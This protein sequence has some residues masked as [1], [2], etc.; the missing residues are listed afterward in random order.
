MACS[1][2]YGTVSSSYWDVTT[3][4]RSV[5]AGISGG[6][7]I[8]ATGLT[9]A[10][11]YQKASY[12][13]LDFSASGHW[14][15]IEGSTRPL[16][17]MEA[18]N[19][20]TNGHA[21]QL[22]AL[23][24]DAYYTVKG[25]IDLSETAN[26]SGIW[27]A[28]GFIPIGNDTNPFTGLLQAS[29]TAV[30]SGLAMSRQ[31]GSV[32]LVGVLGAHGVISG[33][34][35]V[36]AN[37]TGTDAVGALVGI[38][39][40]L[41]TDSASTG[42][43]KGAKAGGLVGWN[44]GII[45]KSSSIAA[46]TAGVNGRVG[47]LVGYQTATGSI[48]DAY[49]GGA[50]TSTAAGNY[51][52]GLV[53]WDV[54]GTISNAY[55]T[56]AV[57]AASGSIGGGLVGRIS[58]SGS[59]VGTL[60]LGYASG[61]VS[62]AGTLGGLVGQQDASTSLSNLY[63]DSGTTAQAAAIGSIV[64]GTRANLVAVGG[65]SGNDAYAQ[66]TYRALNF[67]SYWVI[68]SGDTRPMLSSELQS[69][70]TTPHQLQMLAVAPDSGA[71][72][73]LA[74]DING[75]AVTNPSDVW[76]A[77]TGFAPIGSLSGFST[78]SLDGQNHSISNLVIN[79]PT[80]DNVGLFGFVRSG[81]IQ[82][83]RLVG[84]TVNGGTDVGGLIGLNAS[85]MV[86]SVS[87]SMAVTGTDF[88][89]G[90]VGENMGSLQSSSDSGVTSGGG[91]V[92]GLAG[93]NLGLIDRSSATGTV[94][95]AG[96]FAGGAIGKNQ[97]LVTRTTASGAVTGNYMVGGLT[98]SNTLGGVIA[99][100]QAT[101]AVRGA[102]WTGGLAGNNDGTIARSWAGGA[103]KSIGQL[104]GGL[105][106]KNSGTVSDVY[107]TGKVNGGTTTGGLIG[108][109]AGTATVIRGYAAGVVTGTSQVG[110]VVGFNDTGATVTD[111]YWDLGTTGVAVAAGLDTGTLTGVTAIGA[112]TSYPAD[113]NSSYPALDF[114]AI[115]RSTNSSYGVRPTLDP[116]P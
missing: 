41:I 45:T 108:W 105:I 103:V 99:G 1:A 18:S 94:T 5:A 109:N 60:K 54:G 24:S 112:G 98:G 61:K 14:V 95:T 33:I 110:G 20:I 31:Y 71:S 38:N 63:W 104:T 46:V 91:H 62:G 92:G 13:G 106:G 40:G 70:I 69:K 47:G 115:W 102:R 74:A 55:S 44:Y 29:G 113:T 28:A 15:M 37:I 3:S 97:G 35:L 9:G 57:T 10:A 65:T 66:A 8:G 81:T 72:Y 21:L 17:K 27:A 6:A 100:S 34:Q 30:I 32:G 87:S 25:E 36:G 88:V 7:P 84:G 68:L 52:G 75:S 82:R 107:A 19:V 93:D 78:I 85:G 79:R 43:V 11:R 4:G 51:A 2:N 22:A 16:L 114:T 73:Q 77:S 64:G 23:R 59:A 80:A 111:V 48:T 86:V 12:G 89:G 26:P 116:L 101:G 67:A 76:R 49:A 58:A 90:L 39:H 56:G 83:I 50:V 96:N 42:V 53:G